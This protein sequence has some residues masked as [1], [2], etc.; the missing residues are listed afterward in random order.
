MKKE[1]RIKNS[2]KAAALVIL[3]FFSCLEIQAQEFS[4][5]VGTELPTGISV[6]G[7]VAFP[8]AHLYLRVRYGRFIPLYVD[9][10]NQFAEM[11]GYYNS[12]TS[13]IIYE[14][15]N[16]GELSEVALGYETSRTE[17]WHGDLAYT[18]MC[19][20]SRVR[21]KI[22]WCEWDIDF[23]IKKRELCQ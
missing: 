15:L 4:A 1:N 7:K 16:N 12:A 23:P 21:F 19:M 8:E 18:T 3:I 11:M 22:S 14:S 6:D 5:G 2:V 17:G 13:E 20:I 10:M 9:V